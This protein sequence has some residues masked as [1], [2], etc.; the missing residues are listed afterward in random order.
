[1]AGNFVPMPEAKISSL[2]LNLLCSN[3]TCDMALRC[4]FKG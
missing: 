3:V 4:R 1:M 2:Y